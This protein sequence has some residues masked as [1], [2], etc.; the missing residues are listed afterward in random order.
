[1]SSLDCLSFLSLP[2]VA[3]VR[4][5]PPSL[6]DIVLLYCCKGRECEHLL[7]TFLQPVNKSCQCLLIDKILESLSFRVTSCI[8]YF[9]QKSD[10]G[11][12]LDCI[13]LSLSLSLSTYLTT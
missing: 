5:R 12:Q 8:Y 1:M 9:Y 6:L 13:I 3:G 11:M 4:G 10:Q 7:D 2:V